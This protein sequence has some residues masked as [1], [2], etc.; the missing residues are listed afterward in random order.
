MTNI[1]SSS[2]IVTL[3]NGIRVANFSSPHPFNF[4]DGTVC[5]SCESDRVKAGSLDRM[6]VESPFPGLPGVTAVIPKFK[7]ND[8]LREE[9]RQL[10][11]DPGVDVVLVPFPVLEAI[12]ED[13]LYNELTKSATICVADRLTKAIFIDRFCR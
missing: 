2:P 3:S 4:V 11:S 1:I 8:V 12:R 13:G 7:L 5:P 10:Q 9:L 6:D